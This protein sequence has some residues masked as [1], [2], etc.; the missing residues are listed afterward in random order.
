MSVY[1]LKIV[2]ISLLLSLLFIGCEGGGLTGPTI[3]GSGADPSIAPSSFSSEA[4]EAEEQGDEETEQDAVETE[5]A[6]VAADE[7][8][9]PADEEPPAEEQ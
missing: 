2:V 4:F 5:S 7:R 9:P 6:A 1:I 3:L 8:D